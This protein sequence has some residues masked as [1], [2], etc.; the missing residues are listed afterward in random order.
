MS[1][2]DFIQIGQGNVDTVEII[3]NGDIQNWPEPSSA[4]QDMDCDFGQEGD[5]FIATVTLYPDG[6]A[7]NQV[8]GKVTISASSMSP[9][10]IELEVQ[11]NDD[12]TSSLYT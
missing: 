7:I 5:H 10:I 1:A 6:T 2:G 9:D 11:I 12:L 8:T 3:L 4:S